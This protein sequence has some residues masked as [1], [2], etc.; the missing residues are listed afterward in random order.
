MNDAVYFQ[1]ADTQQNLN[2]CTNGNYGGNFVNAQQRTGPFRTG[3]AS[4]FLIGCGVSYAPTGFSTK[5]LDT[6]DEWQNRQQSGSPNSPDDCN[7]LCTWIFQEWVDLEDGDAG[8]V[9]TLK[10]ESWDWIG[11]ENAGTCLLYNARTLTTD[12]DPAAIPQLVQNSARGDDVFASGGSA[13]G[14]TQSLYITSW[15][16][17]IS[18]GEMTGRYNRNLLAE[19][20]AIGA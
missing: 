5:Q 13:Q 6:D 16:R 4:T 11:T 15:K 9:D 3:R 12:S 2:L 10:C 1:P 20:R 19:R 8:K 18:Y 7:R 14:L 17:G